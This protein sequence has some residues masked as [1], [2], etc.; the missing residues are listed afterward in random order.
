MTLTFNALTF[1]SSTS[2]AY[3]IHFFFFYNFRLGVVSDGGSLI[4]AAF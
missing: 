4:Q 1:V 3:P 2:L